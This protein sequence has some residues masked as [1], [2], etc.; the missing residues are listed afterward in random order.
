MAVLLAR[1]RIGFPFFRFGINNDEICRAVNVVTIISKT[2]KSTPVL[3]IIV[4]TLPEKL[5]SPG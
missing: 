2:Q 3:L 4:Y 1:V 5:H